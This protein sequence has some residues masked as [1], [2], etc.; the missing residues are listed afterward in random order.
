MNN[1]CGIG[2]DCEH[3]SRF[4]NPEKKLLLRVFTKKEIDYCKSKSNPSQ[5]FAA[6][7]AGKEAVIK[8]FGNIDKKIFF[9]KIEIINGK[10]GGPVVKIMEKSLSRYGVKISMSHGKD[11]AIAFAVVTE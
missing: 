6:R 1:V 3:I 11:M 8:A 9:N 7:F 10:G 2:V 5:H 4:K